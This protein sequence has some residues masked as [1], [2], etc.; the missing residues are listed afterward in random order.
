MYISPGGRIRENVSACYDELTQIII[1]WGVFTILIYAACVL[2]PLAKL[3]L[4]HSS[5]IVE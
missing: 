2:P 1:G 3:S 5:N 4:F